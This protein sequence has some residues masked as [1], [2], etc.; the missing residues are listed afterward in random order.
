MIPARAV[1]VDA[2]LAMAWVLQEAHTTPARARLLQWERAGVT[3]LA[4]ALFAAETASACRRHLAGGLLPDLAAAGR[5]LAGVL[6]AVTIQ[7]DDGLLA[8]RALEIATAIGAG[9]AYD[10]LYVAFAERLGLELWTGDQRLYN[11]AHSIFPRVR[12]VG[13]PL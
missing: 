11:A 2:S 9:R 6:V 10:S 5:A 7:P 13:E 12:W 1:V 3:R 8:Q 4:P